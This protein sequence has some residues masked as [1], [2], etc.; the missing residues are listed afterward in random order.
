L[1]AT[2]VFRHKRQR[3]VRSEHALPSLLG[4]EVERPRFQQVRQGDHSDLT[5]SL[6]IVASRVVPEGVA[7][8]PPMLFEEDG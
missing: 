2:S 5:R 4:L 3:N 1:A 7:T 8:H 6:S